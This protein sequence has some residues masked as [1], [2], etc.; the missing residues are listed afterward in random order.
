MPR[1]KVVILG[2]ISKTPVAG[3]VWQTLHYLVGFERLGYE[4]YY[5]EAHGRTPSMFMSTETEDGSVAASQYLAQVMHRFDFDHR[6]AFQALH[7]DG[8]CY[9]LTEQELMRLYQC[10]E[11]IV[12]LHGGTEPRPE[13][14]AN[15]NLIYIET[16]PVLLQ[17]ELHN[18]LESSINFLKQHK[19]LFTFAENYGNADCGLPPAN[20]FTFVPTR[21]PVVLDFWSSADA[22]TREVFTTVGNWSQPWR[23]VTF[24]GET[25]HWSKHHE[26]LKVLDLPARTH[27][28]LELSLSSYTPK[29]QSLL[30]GRGWM[31]R[32]ALDFSTDIDAYKDYITTSRGEFT[33]AKDQ[34]VRLRTGW[35]SDRSAS[36]L[37]AGRPVVTQDTGFGRVLP[38]G[39]G[40]L[41][42]SELG[43]AVAAIEAVNQDYA[44][45][46]RAAW[47]IAAD[48]FDATRVL[49][50]LLVAAGLR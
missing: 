4:A 18:G 20:A 3:V 34:N 23:E 39:T 40:L 10:A 21:Q 15:G 13:H 25:Y 46:S 38:V 5:V 35:F 33:V 11:L 24:E 30:E 1:K 2:M 37:A 42:F 28:G 26:F 41:S 43:G 50:R 47:E 27:Q 44:R 16:D 22:A 19:T 32:H 31:V 29:D 45:H 12:N 8:R 49:H 17:I 14:A 36:Y 6:W 7:S 48:F 9:G